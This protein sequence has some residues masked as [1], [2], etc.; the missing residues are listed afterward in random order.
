MSDSDMAA[1]RSSAVAALGLTG[2]FLAGRLTGSARLGWLASALVSLTFQFRL[3]ADAILGNALLLQT[4]LLCTLGS[5]LVFDAYLANGGRWRL[6][7][8]VGLYLLAVLS[9]EIA[10]PFFVL[11]FALAYL[12]H[13]G[14]PDAQQIVSR[15]VL[16]FTF[17]WVAEED[18]H[19]HVLEM[20]L[21]RTGLANEA[22]LEAEMLRER[23][24]A[25][26][27]PY[28]H[29]N[30][31]V[32]GFIYLAL[33][34]KATHLYYRALARDVEEPLLIDGMQRK[35][36]LE[37]D[38]S[39]LS[40]LGLSKRTAALPAE[41]SGGQ[42]Q[43]V[44]LARALVHEP[45]VLLLDEPLSNLDATVR[46]PLRDEIRRIPTRLGITT[47]FVTTLQEETLSVSG[48]VAVLSNVCRAQA[49]QKW[50]DWMV[51]V[52]HEE[53]L[54]LQVCRSA[55]QRRP[56]D[57]GQDHV[58]GSLFHQFCKPMIQLV[59]PIPHLT[60]MHLQGRGHY[61][62]GCDPCHERFRPGRPHA[63][64]I[65]DVSPWQQYLHCGPG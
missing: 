43:R 50:P 26:V 25:Y 20:Y 19:A 42:Q 33:Q 56:P 47:L 61:S 18:R 41:L 10:W 21:T 48:R 9:Y 2:G 36:A 46:A 57:T 65:K 34:E 40:R 12:R 1:A 55:I 32:E 30:Q 24:A 44:A 31:L 60:T 17:R 37:R 62:Q 29:N 3:H 27:F 5:L 14:L 51:R 35:D 4:I 13:P 7:A 52:P 64:S 11:H 23:Q 8:A 38:R 45:R 49:L 59:H 53:Y 39:L 58:I 28:D 63:P 6:L 54:L 22:E 16:H 15:K